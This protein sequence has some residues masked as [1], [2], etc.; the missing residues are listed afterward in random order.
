M[1]TPVPEGRGSRRDQVLVAAGVATV[2]AT[3]LTLVGWRPGG[4]D[5]LSG[6]AAGVAL[7]G[8]LTGAVLLLLGT[9]RRLPTSTLVLVPSA[10]AVNVAVGQLVAVVGL[11]LYLDSIGTIVVAVL[12]GPAAGMATGILANLIWGVTLAPVA[13]PFSVSAATIGALAGLA[14]R[15]GAFRRIWLAPLAGVLTGAAAAVVSAPVAA[16]VF[17]GVTGGGASAVVAAFRALGSS[18]LTATTLQGLL[19]DPL[20][21]AIT[22]TVAAL[23]L[24]GLPARLWRRFPF[25]RRYATLQT[26]GRRPRPV[27]PPR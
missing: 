14:A 8:N 15:L 18:L 27:S 2:V 26:T 9:V 16:F 24:G 11:P 21:K 22:F 12:G 17:G 10:I 1:S 4:L 3:Y 25:A 6:P 7:V 13:V 19:Q 5:A 23:V 20:D